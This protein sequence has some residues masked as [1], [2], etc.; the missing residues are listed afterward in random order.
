V[1]RRVR[2]FDRQREFK[3]VQEREEFKSSRERES[4]LPVGAGIQCNRRGGGRLLKAPRNDGLRRK[5]SLKV[6]RKVAHQY[7]PL[8]YQEEKEGGRRRRREMS[9]EHNKRDD[10]ERNTGQRALTSTRST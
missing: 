7:R 9:V 3:R 10:E 6:I 2:G 5:H 1:R 8:C 4:N